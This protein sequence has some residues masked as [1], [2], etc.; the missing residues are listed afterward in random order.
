MGC[1]AGRTGSSERARAAPAAV[2][3]RTGGAGC[4]QI[5]CRS[6]SGLVCT[7]TRSGTRRGNASPSPG[8]CLGLATRPGDT[9]LPTLVPASLELK[10]DISRAQAPVR[11]ETGRDRPPRG[12]AGLAAPLTRGREFRRRASEQRCAR[13]CLPETGHHR[14]LTGC[15]HV[16]GRMWARGPPLPDRGYPPPPSPLGCRAYH[17]SVQSAQQDAPPR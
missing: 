5:S 14:L 4:S 12:L 1:R 16:A 17:L 10:R 6:A 2:G 15:A 13:R 8:L 9:P 3:L 11:R 7:G